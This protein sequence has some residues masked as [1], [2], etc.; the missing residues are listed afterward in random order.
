MK[1]NQ[2]NNIYCL[3]GLRIIFI[4]ILLF[5]L[6]QSVLFAQTLSDSL[7]LEKK[8]ET[9]KALEILYKLAETTKPENEQYFL[10]I[11]KI[12]SLET[13]ISKIVL[14]LESKIL[15]ITNTNQK[16]HALKK[17]AVLMEL[18]GNIENAGDYYE[19][20]YKLNS[21]DENIVYLIN[22][23]IINLETGNIEKALSLAKLAESKAQK[24]V[25]AQKDR[26][27]VV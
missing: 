2:W 9:K 14:N 11:D 27:S 7:E 21:S 18:S 1:S 8:G 16:N 13:D 5:F 20:I 10:I 12:I 19:M 4:P 25:D 15:K 23:A 24:M 22:A 3:I 26:K 17:I 6:I